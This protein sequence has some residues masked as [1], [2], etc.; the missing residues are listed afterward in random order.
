MESDAPYLVSLTHG[1]MLGDHMKIR[2]A[3]TS[4]VVAIQRLY[5]ELDKY[6]A[7][8]L[9]GVFRSLTDD[10]R[11]DSVVRDWIEDTDADY[12]VAEDDGRLIGFL[13]IRKAAH[14]WYPMFRTHEFAVIENAFVEESQ[15][16][17]TI[18]TQLFNAA[19]SWTRKCGLNHIQTTMWSANKGAKKF[20]IRQGFRP[21][22]EKLELDLIE[23]K[24]EQADAGDT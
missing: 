8:L 23:R 16:G 19:I 15:R 1:V 13:N 6:H 24:A 20:Y 5:R 4:D 11:P 17:G 18:G 3:K 7:D 21:L 22:T 2:Q 14:P 9:P 12:L 10:A